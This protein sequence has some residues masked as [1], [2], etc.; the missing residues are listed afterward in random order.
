MRTAQFQDLELPLPLLY[1]SSQ[2]RPYTEISYLYLGF[3][4]P[5]FLVFFSCSVWLISSAVSPQSRIVFLEWSFNWLSFRVHKGPT[6]QFNTIWTSMGALFLPVNLSLQKS[7]LVSATS[8]KLVCWFWSSP[9]L[10]APRM[11][12]PPSLPST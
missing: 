4:F 8:L 3:L 10:R 11:S 7:T 6:N 9:P 5:C 2:I 1:V 12:S